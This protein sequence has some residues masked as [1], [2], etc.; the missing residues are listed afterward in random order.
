MAKEKEGGM[1]NFSDPHRGT[2]GALRRLPEPLKIVAD[3]LDGSCMLV[4]D[5]MTLF[6]DAAPED[7]P[8]SIQDRGGYISV[9]IGPIGTPPVIDCWRVISYVL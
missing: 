1:V 9:E 6:E 4:S 8:V 2:G 3:W 7:E 5:A